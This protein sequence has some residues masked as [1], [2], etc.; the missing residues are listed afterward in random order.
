[1]NHHRVRVGL[2]AAV[3]LLVQ[4]ALAGPIAAQDSTPA[5]SPGAGATVE[6]IAV[7]TPGSRTN[8][9]WDQQAA[10][11]VDAVAAEAGIE[12]VVAENGGYEDITPILR[13]LAA[14]GADLII[15]HASG[16]RPSARSSPLSPA[17]QSRSL[18]TLARSHQ[19][20]CLTS[21]PMTRTSLT[22]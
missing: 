18:K 7:V 19:V 5:A 9:G 6:Q 12:G 21:R 2:I 1:M 22:S 20:W 16:F 4:T 3:A 17:F 15:C 8:Q 10:D 13:D 11:A 14:G